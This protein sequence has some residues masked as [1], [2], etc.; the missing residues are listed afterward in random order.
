MKPLLAFI[1]KEFL[2]SIRTGKIIILTLLFILLGIM[3]PAIAKLTPW[4]MEMLS[5]TMIQGGLIVTN[6]KVDALTSWI[7]FFKNIPV[8]LITFVMI[9]SDIFTR[10]YQSGTLVLVLTKGLSK[11]QVLLAKTAVLLFIWAVEYGIY[12]AITYGYNAYFWD[13]SMVNNLFLSIT[14]W[15]LFGL[16]V[17]CLLVL[18]SSILPNNAGVTLCMGGTVLLAYLLS[19]IPKTTAYSPAL[20]ININALLMGREEVNTYLKAVV[21]TISMCIL[22]ISVS[23]PILN[24]REL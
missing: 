18:F 10:E 9:F 11:Y 13:N 14:L 19:I 8:L 12:F 1:K 7:Q 17:M 5:D 21:I 2:E 15:W 16:W 22:C 6:I 4:I 3:N 23:I 20:L 24:K